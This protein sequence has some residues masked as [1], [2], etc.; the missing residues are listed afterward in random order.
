MCAN[1]CA[2]DARKPAAKPLGRAIT[3]WQRSSSVASSQVSANPRVRLCFAP[4]AS[5]AFGRL[6]RKT[7]MLRKSSADQLLRLI[8]PFERNLRGRTLKRVAYIADLSVFGNARFRQ[9][10]PCAERAQVSPLRSARRRAGNQPQP[11][12]GG[13]TY[14]GNPSQANAVQGYA[15]N[16]SNSIRQ[17]TL[18]MAYQRQHSWSGHGWP[19]SKGRLVKQTERPIIRMVL[20]GAGL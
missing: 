20:S 11:A 17:Y 3:L 19:P 16:Q 8:G 7:K 10:G 4:L 1:S 2:V 12:I 14:K 9:P 18:P 13:S 6:T 15:Y 5:V